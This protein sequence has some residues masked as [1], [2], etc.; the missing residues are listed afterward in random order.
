MG[1]IQFL[2]LSLIILVY[3]VIGGGLIAR[4][5]TRTA[6]EMKEHNVPKHEEALV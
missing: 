4:M 5:I 6:G 1:I 3:V 2:L